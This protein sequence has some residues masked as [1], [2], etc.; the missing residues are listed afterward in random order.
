MPKQ[1]IVVGMVQNGHVKKYV[2]VCDMHV[3]VCVLFVVSKALTSCHSFCCKCTHLGVHQLFFRLMLDII[4]VPLT[5]RTKRD[6][7]T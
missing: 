4:S 7:P 5:L 1:K 3:F 2:C 6:V